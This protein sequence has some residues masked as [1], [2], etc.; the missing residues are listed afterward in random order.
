[1]SRT[2]PAGYSLA[3][4]T[5]HWIIAV[6]VIAQI[7]FHDHIV[8]AA[9]AIGHGEAIPPE[10]LLAANLH[11][12]FGIAILGLAV[13]RLALRITVGAPPAP[14]GT[15]ALQ[16]RVAS[17]IHWAFYALLFMGPI[18]GLVA[19]YVNPE[20]GEAHEVIKS[21]FIVLILLH[22]AGALQHAIFKRDGVMRRMLVPQRR[23]AVERRAA[24]P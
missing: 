17:V 21:A 22:V 13:V 19:W 18:T 4:I 7:V 12:W 6:L 3:Q 2:A 11:V 5:L 14:A 23:A 15:S 9:D 10:S 20:A 16:A 8:A 24:R 1:M